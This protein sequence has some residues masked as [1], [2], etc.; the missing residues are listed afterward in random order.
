MDNLLFVGTRFTHNYLI[1][2]YNASSILPSIFRRIKYFCNVLLLLLHRKINKEQLEDRDLLK[3]NFAP[4]QFWCIISSAPNENLTCLPVGVLFHTDL[5]LLNYWTFHP[6]LRSN[7]DKRS[8][9][10]LS[11]ARLDSTR[12]VGQYTGWARCIF[13]YRTLIIILVLTGKLF[14]FFF[15]R[16]PIVYRKLFSLSPVVLWNYLSRIIGML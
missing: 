10:E 5:L 8:T 13:L 2:P 12:R 16:P 14:S 7:A 15:L 3:W 11:L 9:F 4:M 1:G 6:Y